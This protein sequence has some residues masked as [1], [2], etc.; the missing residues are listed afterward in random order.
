MEVEMLR[1]EFGD[2]FTLVTP[3]IRP[4]TASHDQKRVTRPAA[5]VA[6]GSDYLVIGRAIT[7]AENPIQVVDRIVESI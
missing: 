3:G 2:R 1:K 6:A 4:G 5:A 7:E